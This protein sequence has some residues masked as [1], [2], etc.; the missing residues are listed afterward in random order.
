MEAPAEVQPIKIYHIEG[1]RSFRVAWLCE[2][3]GI[4]YE[5]IYE[6]GDIL[7]S[8]LT[9]RASHPIMPM[10]PVVEINGKAV[11]ESGAIL[12]IL[13]ERNGGGAMKPP[14][15]SEDFLFHTQWMYFAEGT[16]QARMLAWRIVA[17]ALGMEV[18]ELPEGYRPHINKA[19]EVPPPGPTS[20]L[21]FLIGPR[22]IF[23]AVEA[24]L[25]RY[26][27]FGGSQFSAADIM[28][29]YQVRHAMLMS[30]IDLAEYPTSAKWRKHVE[31]RDAY[32]RADQNCHP[33]GVDEHGLP[34]GSP[35][36]FPVRSST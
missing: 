4:P 14:V 22:A 8:M 20:I 12:D 2:E 21:E 18:D 13:I 36:P 10:A 26:P 1:R 33:D 19:A 29:H 5:L 3:L 31:E 30:Q 25:T 23:D 6:R 28:M 24:H 16:A 15:A 7:R 32:L 34:I 35:P 9:I 27:Y 11:V 17:T